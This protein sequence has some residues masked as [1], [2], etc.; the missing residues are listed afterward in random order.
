MRWKQFRE[1]ENVENRIPAD[2]DQSFPQPKEALDKAEKAG[3]KLRPPSPPPMRP[4]VSA[5]KKAEL[6]SEHAKRKG[7]EPNSELYQSTLPQT[8]KGDSVK[9]LG[10][11]PD[12]PD[13][14]EQRDPTPTLYTYINEYG[15]KAYKR[16]K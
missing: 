6:A 5:E 9:H 16:L 12:Y 10:M 1:S 4:K 15:P 7:W 8:P 2:V 3:R 13:R 14:M 11:I